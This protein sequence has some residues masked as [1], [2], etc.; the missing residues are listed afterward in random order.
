LTVGSASDRGD[1]AVFDLA[2]RLSGTQ[3]PRFCR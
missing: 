2:W 1:E 3:V